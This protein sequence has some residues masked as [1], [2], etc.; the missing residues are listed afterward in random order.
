MADKENQSKGI[1]DM[2]QI[3]IE[4]KLTQKFYSFDTV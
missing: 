1:R 2:K 4:F 3:L